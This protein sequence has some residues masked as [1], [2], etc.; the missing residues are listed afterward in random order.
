MAIGISF[1]NA[2]L[3]ST[4]VPG[5]RDPLFPGMSGADRFAPAF[6]LVVNGAVMPERI[7]ARIESVEYEDNEELFDQLKIVLKGFIYDDEVGRDVPIP[8]WV[9]STTIFSE[10]NIVWLRL[11]YNATL[12]LVGGAEIVKREFA[13]G[14]N[15]KA[16]IIAYE[17]LH[18]MANQ[19]AEKAIAYKGKLS[20]TIVKE[21][22]QKSEYSG[23]IGALFDT[24][25]IKKLPAFTPRAEV[26][27]AQ[28]SDYHFIKRMALVRGWQFYTRFD[29]ESKKFALFYGPDVDQQDSVFKYTY[30]P[31][32]ELLLG[33]DT[34][35]EITPEVNLIDQSTE[36]E[37][38]SFNEKTGK[39]IGHKAKYVP[40]EDG[41]AAVN[42]KF[43]QSN[44]NFENS[45]LKNP[46]YYRFS[47]FGNNKRLVT[48]RPFKNEGEAKKFI[49]NWARQ[50]IKNFITCRGKVVGNEFIQSRQIH[51][52]L[53]LGL[54][55]S[56][57]Q[58]KPAKW[59][60]TKV[61]HKIS[62]GGGD[63]VYT[64]E[65]EARKTVEWLPDSDLGV[66]DLIGAFAL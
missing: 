8:E 35:I 51:F 43:T 1:G 47:A 33:E 4:R 6:Q 28:E 42:R 29:E 15:P 56:G 40:L 16:T 62:G 7:T 38:I 31:L 48:D 14:S 37:I 45:E 2:I 55:F 64:T 10:G 32:H 3:P 26:Q 53:G 21:L 52:F 46:T 11:G 24:S 44:I 20:A 66:V 39:R 65:F 12:Q 63:L 23:V 5:L 17:P 41:A 13:Y 36:I 59:Y 27:K 9:Q 49:I 58:L 18:R 19:W 50:T 22:G 57:S 60:L 61:I 25:N 30:N 54:T 34:I